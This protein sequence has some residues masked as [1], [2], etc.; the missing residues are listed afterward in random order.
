SRPTPHSFVKR[1]TTSAGQSGTPVHVTRGSVTKT[2][3]FLERSPS[4]IDNGRDRRIKAQSKLGSVG[5]YHRFQAWNTPS[6]KRAK[7]G[8]CSNLE[9]GLRIGDSPSVSAPLTSRQGNPT[10]QIHEP[11]PSANY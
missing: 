3:Y 10:R 5:N 4:G 7:S 9:S 8:A 2:P 11:R 1:D 6:S